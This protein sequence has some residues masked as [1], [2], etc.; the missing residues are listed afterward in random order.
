MRLV[1]SRN[2]E[3]LGLDVTEISRIGFRLVFCFPVNSGTD[4]DQW[5]KK[6]NLWNVDQHLENLFDGVPKSEAMILEFECNDCSFRLAIQPGERPE[7]RLIGSRKHLVR[8][9][10]LPRSQRD[11][12]ALNE[13]KRYKERVVRIVDVDSFAENP[14]PDIKAGEF[15]RSSSDKIYQV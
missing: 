8:S 4:A 11:Q 12:L 14:D 15:A 5:G 9:K 3:R 13:K 7:N 1:Y 2:D 6:R 10:D